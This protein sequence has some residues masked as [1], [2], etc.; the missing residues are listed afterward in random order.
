MCKRETKKMGE[1]G[2]GGG[3][4][5]CVCVCPYVWSRSL[6]AATAWLG[7]VPGE[8]E[9]VRTQRYQRGRELGVGGSAGARGRL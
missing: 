2:L 7:D 5:V 8:R 1:Y 6:P 9:R 3:V 4:C